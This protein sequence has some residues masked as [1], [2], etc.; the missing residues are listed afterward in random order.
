M[1]D[2]VDAMS[3][4]TPV[5]INQ[6]ALVGQLFDVPYDDEEKRKLIEIEKR[7]SKKHNYGKKE[8]E[9]DIDVDL[10]DPMNYGDDLDDDDNDDNNDMGGTWLR[11]EGKKMNEDDLNDYLNENQNEEDNSIGKG[12]QSSDTLHDAETSGIFTDVTPLTVVPESILTKTIYLCHDVEEGEF[13]HNYTREEITQMMG[14]D[15][16]SFKFDFEEELN[17]IDISE[18]EEYVF[19]NIPEA[20]DFDK[21]VVEDDSDDENFK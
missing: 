6:F 11:I 3:E 1:K 2:K 14:V 5:D 18:P 9:D 21:V 16:H 12:E 20:N 17:N 10:D 8:D 15:E 4:I 7:K 19:K 13:V